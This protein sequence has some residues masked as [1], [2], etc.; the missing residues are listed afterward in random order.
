MCYRVSALS[1]YV[2][3]MCAFICEY[4]YAILHVCTVCAYIC[5]YTYTRY[6]VASNSRLLQIIRLFCRI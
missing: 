4:P 2:C 3:T 1:L 5:Q 6:G